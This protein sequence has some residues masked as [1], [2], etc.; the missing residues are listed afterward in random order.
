MA[1][2]D[3]FNDD[4]FSLQSLTDAINVTPEGQAVPTTLDS[5]FDEEG[6]TT[7]AVSI[8][9]NNGQLALVPAADRG[10]PGATVEDDSRDL[11]PFNTLHLPLRDTVLA[12]A[13]QNVRAFGKES[14]L[15]TMQSVVN[16]R[17][18]KLRKKIDTTL[19]Y[20]RLGAVTGKVYDAD[21]TRVL[22]DLYSRFGIT[23][24]SQ[25]LALGS[26]TTKVRQKIIDAKRKAE[27][28][29]AG[30][31]VITGWLGILG[32]G[33]YDAFTGHAD[34]EKSFERWRDGEFF[35]NDLRT[36]FQFEGV[37]WQ[38]YYGKVG[39]VTFIDSDVGYLI[40]ITSEDLFQTKFAP[41]NHVD[42]VN[43][44]GRPY[45]A[46]QKILDHGVGV[47]L[48]AQSNPLTINTRPNIVIKLTKA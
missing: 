39:S 34:V 8:E 17:L 26:E 33:I 3:I 42:A 19:T 24:K 20:H 14:E 16:K 29:L 13:I 41:A 44:I 6:V 2:I 45:Y 28:A 9:R 18:A 35:R 11:I 43:T 36:G 25:S 1:S 7:T 38:E 5:L 21:G 37:E 32:R 12:D 30:E 46:T 23:Q 47:E 27:D 31:A 15:E 4:A 40:P 48:K 22:L 10:A